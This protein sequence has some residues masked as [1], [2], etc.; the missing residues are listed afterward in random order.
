VRRALA[1]ILLAGLVLPASAH[2][3]AELLSSTPE[4]G[5][6]LE[7]APRAVAFRFNEP[8]EAS[9]GA[10]RVFDGEGRRV[11]EDA[12]RR[13]GGRA[14]AVA[15]GLPAHLGPGTYTATYRVVSADGHPVS[16]GVVF[17]VG[18]GRPAAVTV[19]DLLE[20]GDA[21]PVTRAGFAV[22]RGL[23]YAAVALVLGE[24]LFLVAVW[25][26]ILRRL[27][28]A[29][30]AWREAAAAF[31]R[32]S[33]ALLGAGVATGA[34]TSVLG[35]AFQG[36]VAGGTSLWA[37]LD[38]Q[39][40]DA[41]LDTRFGA[42]WGLRAVLWL[43][44][45]A[46]V[47]W[48]RPALRPAA[49]RPAR[50][51]ADG[52]AV[53]PGPGRAALAAVVALTVALALT[54]ALAG[55]ARV[56]SPAWLIVSADALHVLAMAAWTGPLVLLLAAVPAA[57]RRLDGPAR[58]RLLAATLV[59]VSPIA[60]A[61]V[62][63]LLG[64]G[65]AQSIAHLEALGGLWGTGFGRAILVK[66]ALFLTLCAIGAHHRR[67]GIPR[68]RALAEAGEPPAGAGRTLRRALR[69]EV[70]LFA[71][72][73]A[74]TSILVASSPAAA[75]PDV[76]SERVAVG[77]AEV[78]VTMEPLRT[79]PNELHFYLFD[80]R[81]GTPLRRVRDL[82]VELRLPAKGIGPLA[83]QVSRAG[84]GH[85]VASRADVGVPGDW[86]LLL[87]LRLSKFDVHSTTLPVGIR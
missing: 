40:L 5:E 4:R 31:A 36:A 29:S 73:L 39:V 66:A 67:R 80:A 38:P 64:T 79:G 3:H 33:R 11:D 70:A 2:G 86:E 6:R 76:L 35:L 55:H 51:G 1:L 14:D 23:A 17:V 60:L 63:V 56:A 57:T 42:L 58:T 10:V 34:V 30:P 28:G 16:G 78:E 68:L 65:V 24:L 32:R 84:P 20:E 71:G 18:D 59:R 22:V 72:V 52:L 44:V 85:Y 8:V 19:S 77:P 27:A 26:P 75:G 62:L 43:V 12:L 81:D 48:P 41:V 37:A 83:V 61:A 15:V 25:A 53:A 87:R 13:P 82:R 9:F 74:A 45:G 50:L 46:A 7:R 54:A 69:A 21:G 49:V 47:L